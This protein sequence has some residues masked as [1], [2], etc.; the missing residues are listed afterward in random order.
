MKGHRMTTQI[1]SQSRLQEL[2][3]YNEETGIFTWRIHA[4]NRLSNSI[5]GSLCKRGYFD[6]SVDGKNYRAHRLA[7]LYVYGNFP[8]GVIDHINGIKSD[9][10][11]VNLR[12]V[13]NAKNLLSFRKVSSNNTSGFLGVSKNHD[14]W[15]AEINVNVQKINLG[16]YPTKE[17][18][19][20]AYVA[21]KLFN[22]KKHWVGLDPEEQ[23]EMWDRAEKRQAYQGVP[24][25]AA[26]IQEVEAKLRSKNT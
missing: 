22:E 19:S 25:L 15:R 24:A 2:L 18:A 16:T 6:I 26:L 8:I 13:T 9:N 5:A 3:Q 7:W 12:D 21:A 10:R 4:G 14:G 11:L 17:E 23:S 1:L 20:I